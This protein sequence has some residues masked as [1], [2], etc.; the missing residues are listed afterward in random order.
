M[1]ILFHRIFP[2]NRF[3]KI[4]KWCIAYMIV[5]TAVFFFLIVFQCSPVQY[6]WEKTIPGQCIDLKALTYSGAV[7]SAIHDIGT[8]LLP[9]NELRKL[10]MDT[11]KK[12]GVILVFI[13]GSW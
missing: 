8:L 2:D 10:Q 13:I 12:I 1:L 3:R 5:H 6:A 4:I 11:G 9:L 7:F